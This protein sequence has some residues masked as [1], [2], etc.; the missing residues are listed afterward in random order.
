M[1]A[2]RSQPLKQQKSSE[3]PEF[4]RIALSDHSRLGLP[5]IVWENG[6]VVEKPA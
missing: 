5:I 2:P 6:K 3:L 1:I 4:A